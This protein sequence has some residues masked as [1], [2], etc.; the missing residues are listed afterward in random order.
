VAAFEPQNDNKQPDDKQ[1]LHPAHRDQIA[2]SG[3]EIIV[4][5][6]DP[7]REPLDE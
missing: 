4:V 5:G 7:K 1:P 2:E 6:F 3:L